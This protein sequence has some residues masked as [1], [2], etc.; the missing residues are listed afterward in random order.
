V[1]AV[2]AL[3]FELSVEPAA[4][5][6]EQ[7]VVAEKDAFI[8]ELKALIE[9]LEGQVQDCRRTKFGPKS[10]KLDPAQ[11]ELALE[12]EPSRRHRFK[13]D[14]E[15]NRHRRNASANRRRR[16]EDRS[17][18]AGPRET[19]ATRAAQGTRLAEKPAARRAC[20]RAGQHRLP[21]R[22]R[23]HGRDRRG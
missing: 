3:Q 13:P 2:S 23:R 22:L 5:Q 8:T 7:A 17:Q 18:R 19:Q 10:E 20:D 4:R 21:L 16:G 11:L 15:R 14:G 6:H 1:K 9:T 12:G